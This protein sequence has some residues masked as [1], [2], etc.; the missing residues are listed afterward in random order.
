MLTIALHREN[1]ESLRNQR[2]GS[3]VSSFYFFNTVCVLVFF[4][5]HATINWNIV[6]NSNF[7]NST[8]LYSEMWNFKFRKSRHEWTKGNK[9]NGSLWSSSLIC[10][11]G[12]CSVI[13]NFVYYPI[14]LLCFYAINW[15]ITMTWLQIFESN[16]K[17]S[18]FID[19]GQYTLSDLYYIS[20]PIMIHYI[21]RIC[22]INRKCRIYCVSLFIE[23]TYVAQIQMYEILNE[24]LKS[25]N[26]ILFSE[27]LVKIYDE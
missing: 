24:K 25:N 6:V 17:S 22:N 27:L 4:L 13:I 14:I 10:N 20:G 7:L 5:I 2:N 21:N 18:C 23:S 11:T 16:Q 1:S 12:N 15:N 9:M 26:Y 19:W 3:K 8:V